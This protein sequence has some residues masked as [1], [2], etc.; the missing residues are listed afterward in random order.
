MKDKSGCGS[1][2][3][4]FLFAFLC[5]ALAYYLFD[6]VVNSDMPMWAKYIILS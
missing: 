6:S 1:I 5:S 3:F 4:W 2:I